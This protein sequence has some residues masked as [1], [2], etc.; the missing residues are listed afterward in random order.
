MTRSWVSVI[1][2]CPN[3]TTV[4]RLY[5]YPLLPRLHTDYCPL[6]IRNV[7]DGIG[8]Q[9]VLPKALVLT[10]MGPAFSELLQGLVA[11]RLRWSLKK[12][13]FTCS[14]AGTAER[15]H[16]RI[17]ALAETAWVDHARLVGT[18]VS[19]GQRRIGIS[20]TRKETVVLHAVG[21]P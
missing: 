4:A 11:L 13:V 1:A 9:C 16:H 8:V 2:G 20:R 14:D 12:T 5:L 15:F 19:S 10:V 21:I 7:V 18:D 3:A 17:W 6:W